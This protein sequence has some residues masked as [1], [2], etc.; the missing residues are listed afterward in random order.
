M[1]EMIVGGEK[2]TIG[3]IKKDWNV[4]VMFKGETRSCYPRMIGYYTAEEAIKACKKQYGR[5]IAKIFWAKPEARFG[6]ISSCYIP[7]PESL[8]SIFARLGIKE[9]DLCWGV[10]PSEWAKEAARKGLL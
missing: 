9:E 8:E 2:V 4:R 7:T 6:G 5:R 1:F 3:A 10:E